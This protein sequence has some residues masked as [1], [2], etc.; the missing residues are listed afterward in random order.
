MKTGRSMIALLLALAMVFS[1]CACGQKAE[2]APSESPQETELPETN[3]EQ[4]DASPTVGGRLPES[5]KGRKLSDEELLALSKDDLPALRAAISTVEDA[6][7][8]FEL[9]K[10]TCGDMGGIFGIDANDCVF[11]TTGAMALQTHPDDQ[12]SADEVSHI[13]AWMLQDDYEGAGALVEL[14]QTGGQL[15]LLCI[16]G[17]GGWH[18]INVAGLMPSMEGKWAE[19]LTPTYQF[20]EDLAGPIA[21]MEYNNW[22]ERALVTDLDYG[23]CFLCGVGCSAFVSR[24]HLTMLRELPEDRRTF[25][26]S[27]EEYTALLE[28]VVKM[29]GV[30][31]PGV[32]AGTRPAQGAGKE[33]EQT[34]PVHLREPSASLLPESL[35]GRK[36]SDK[37]LRALSGTEPE[38]M[39]KAI[40]TAEDAAAWFALYGSAFA[41]GSAAGVN[42]YPEYQ[43]YLPASMTLYQTAASYGTFGKD[44]VSLIAAWLLQDDYDGTG[45]VVDLEPDGFSRCLLYIPQEGENVLINM[46]SLI[47]GETS[48]RPAFQI[49]EDLGGA[50]AD[51]SSSSAGERALVTDLDDMIAFRSS[52]QQAAFLELGSMSILRRLPEERRESMLP[53]AECDGFLRTAAWF[54]GLDYH[55]MKLPSS[56]TEKFGVRQLESAEI[57]AALGGRVLGDRELARLK[58]DD[59]A[60]LRGKLSTIGDVAAWLKLQNFEYWDGA[61]IKNTPSTYLQYYPTAEFMMHPEGLEDATTTYVGRDS[62]NLLAAWLLQDDFEDCGAI[63]VL[64]KGTQYGHL[65]YS[66]VCIGLGGEHYIVN[67]ASLTDLVTSSGDRERERSLDA[68]AV[69]DLGKLSDY[70]DYL[71]V[72]DYGH[73]EIGLIRDLDRNAYYYDY[74]DN[75]YFADRSCALYVQEPDQTALEYTLTHGANGQEWV[76]RDFDIGDFNIPAA[77]GGVVLSDAEIAA[78]VGQDVDAVAQKVNTVPDLIRYLCAGG[79]S[80]GNCDIWERDAKDRGITWHF[81]KTART[82]NM[83]RAIDCGATANLVRRLLDGDYPTVGYVCHTYENGGGGGHVYNY[84]YDGKWYYVLDLTS[85]TGSHYDPKS[86][87]LVRL[88]DLSEYVR[89]FNGMGYGTYLPVIYA[90]DAP[91]EIPLAWGNGE[92]GCSVT[93]YPTGTELQ[94]IFEDRENG[95]S[96]G[97]R[98]MSEKTAAAIALAREDGVNNWAD[99][100]AR[101]FPGVAAY[102]F[103]K[104]FGEASMSYDEMLALVW[105]ADLETLAEKIKTVPDLMMF[106]CA[107]GYSSTFK[108]EGNGDIHIDTD[109][110]VI[111]HY[112]HYAE[113]CRYFPGLG[114]GQCDALTRYLLDGD[115][116][117]VGTI[118]CTWAEG[119]GGG[120]NFNYLRIGDQYYALDMDTYEMSDYSPKTKAFVQ[121][122]SDLAAFREKYKA[123]YGTS[124]MCCYAMTRPHEIPVGWEGN[125]VKTSYLPERYENEIR[126]LWTT[127]DEGYTY[128]FVPLSDEV[129]AYMDRLRAAS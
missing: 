13:A 55:P 124:M 100:R 114:C 121:I 69:K 109:D 6:A 125:S 3:A 4:Q 60:A 126:I 119:M 30:S 2:T 35:R 104:A 75:L 38:A 17:D 50:I 54:F 47:T 77:L 44:T 120:H 64:A 25:L 110:G 92:D 18:L 112:N 40:S 7:A 82:A 90:Y 83:T 93:W 58:T 26:P 56:V 57:S 52:G 86:L 23:V 32:G 88:G 79:F 108:C 127:E 84:I 11:L 106:F 95:Y 42:E 96:V 46:F 89:A 49:A 68:L 67:M 94:I 20:T 22:G 99:H 33:N 61:A 51:L 14:L 62:V 73:G 48:G 97:Y 71:A 10:P 103:P 19:R 27:E 72:D 34:L 70:I 116:D 105:T 81:N 101:S 5:L 53:A 24:E 115:Y 74:G 63:M 78:L 36:L 91:D 65:N 1:L 31:I 122:G 37:K 76:F 12:F 102:K 21:G 107:A 9:R 98:D 8:W 111:W 41:E 16:P 118:S 80:F 59:M 129:E 45:V 123:M 128:R 29:F 15:V 66:A 85:V 28:T 117:E 39:R 43:F 113:L 87:A